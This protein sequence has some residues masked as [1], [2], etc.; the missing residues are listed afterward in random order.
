MSLDHLLHQSRML[1]KV[2]AESRSSGTKRSQLGQPTIRAPP[3][4]VIWIKLVRS[5]FLLIQSSERVLD[6]WD[7]ETTVKCVGSCSVDGIVDGAVVED[8]GDP[9][10]TGIFVST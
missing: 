6:L 9:H 4:S 8:E 7:L 10:S 1:D 2:E 5:R 3:N